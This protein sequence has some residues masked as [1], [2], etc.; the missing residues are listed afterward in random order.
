MTTALITF[1]AIAVWFTGWTTGARIALTARMTRLIC[2][3]GNDYLSLCR[4]Y[5]G[6]ECPTPIGE[7]RA[8]TVYDAA[9]ALLIGLGWPWLILSWLLVRATPVTP[10][11]AIRQ[12]REQEARLDE[13]QRAIERLTRQVSSGS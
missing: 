5:H 12:L 11:E 4:E 9:L 2:P 1:L 10:G 13:Q 8:R 3:R 6:Q 7:V